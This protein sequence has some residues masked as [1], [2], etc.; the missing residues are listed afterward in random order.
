MRTSNIFIIAFFIFILSGMLT[1]FFVTKNHK[2]I[3]D[4][5]YFSEEMAL[6]HFSVIVGNPDSEFSIESSDTNKLK[7]S[8]P[9]K[10]KVVMPLP[11]L[12]RNDTLYINKT[13]EKKERMYTYVTSDGY[14]QILSL[15]V[16]C[17]GIKKLIARQ[18]NH[19]NIGY[20]QSDSLSIES[21]KGFV[22]LGLG[23]FDKDQSMVSKIGKLTYSGQKKSFLF[24]ER[25][26]VEKMVV[27]LQKSSVRI[28]YGNAIKS[29]SAAIKD[30]SNFRYHVDNRD[31]P[32]KMDF[33]SD[34][35]SC[36]FLD[37]N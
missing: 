31:A 24:I 5:N 37:K 33:K 27:K 8:Y 12:V 15:V 26:Q 19:I 6:P 30:S 13:N 20:Y 34:E 18:T 3:Q 23:V 21:D 2:K 32:T 36:F 22:N 7:I 9:G 14:K 29:I 35:S 10:K 28:N 16:Q 11:F 25:T 4:K 17:A 1:L